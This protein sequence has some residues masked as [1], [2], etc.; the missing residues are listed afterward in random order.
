MTDPYAEY[1]ETH[2]RGPLALFR[3]IRALR[4]LPPDATRD[5][6]GAAAYDLRTN[7]EAMADGCG[8]PPLLSIMEEG[9]LLDLVDQIDEGLDRLVIPD[10]SMVVWDLLSCA[11]EI[12]PAWCAVHDMVAETHPAYRSMIRDEI[13]RMADPAQV[14][15]CPDLRA[16]LE[17]CEKNAPWAHLSPALLQRP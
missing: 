11:T 5:Q 14:E 1:V 7:I 6:I 17:W 8:S 13:S 9:D 16:A 2:E 15:S 12:F 3:Q 10:F 4:N